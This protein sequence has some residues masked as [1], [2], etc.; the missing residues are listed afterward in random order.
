MIMDG[1]GL[2]IWES[3]PGMVFLRITG[4]IKDIMITA[5]GK[6]VA[7]QMIENL[8]MKSPLID[9]FVVCGDGQ[10]YL[11][12]LVTLDVDAT[13][14][15]L[16]RHGGS[17]VAV[18]SLSTHPEVRR[19]IEKHIEEQNRL[20]AKYETIKRFAILDNDLSIDGG[21]LTPTYKVRR[22]AISR[23]YAEIIDA[24]YVD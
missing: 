18:D 9:H 16:K 15:H 20:L 7:P 22:K 21:V 1:L 2:G 8:M 6:N 10:K 23:K 5:G 17:D 3:F 4:R 13:L 11:T 14:K 12:A 19:L 24:L